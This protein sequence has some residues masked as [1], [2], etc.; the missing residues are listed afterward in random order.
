MRYLL[1]FVEFLILI[2]SILICNMFNCLIDV[3]VNI[4]GVV[5]KKIF[6]VV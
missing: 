4:V 6:K 2:S 3:G 5:E 1:I